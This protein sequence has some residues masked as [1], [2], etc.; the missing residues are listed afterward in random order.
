[1][2]TAPGS[3]VAP[4]EGDL[5]SSDE[6]RPHSTGTAPEDE[7]DLEVYDEGVEF[8]TEEEIATLRRVA[9]KM[10]IGAFAIVIVEL[11]ERFAYYG[12]SGPFQNYLQNPLPPGSTSGAPL[13]GDNGTAGALN[14]GQTAATGLQNMFSFLAYIT[15]IVCG[16]IADVK[17]GRYKTICVFCVVYFVGLLIIT[18]T[19]IPSALSRGAGLAGWIVG[20]IVVAFGTGGIKSNVSPLVADQVRR[21]RMFIKV[22]PSGERVIVDPNVTITRIYNLFYWCINVGSLSAIATTELEHRVGF[23]AAFI[24]P[25]LVFLGTPIVLVGARKTYHKVP[26]RG[27]VVIE[28]FRVT[29]IALRGFWTNPIKYLRESNVTGVWN[30]AKPSYILAQDD[31]FVEEVKRTAKACQ[32]FLFFPLYWISYNQITSNLVSM[33]ADMSLH[34]VPNDLF[35]NFDPIAL[36]ILI[37]I[38][39]IFVYPGLRRIGIIARPV[40][41]IWLGFMFGAVAMV[42]SAVLQHYIYKT[43]PCGDFASGCADADGNPTPSTINVWVQIPAYIL[44]AI[45]EVF[46]SITGLEYAYNKAPKRMKSL[47]MA[48]FLFMVAI[49]NALNAALA[50]VAIDPK[51]VGNYAGIGIATFIAGMVFYLLFYK[52]DRIEEA[53]NEIGKGK[54]YDSAETLTQEDAEKVVAVQA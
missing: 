20:A 54:R 7:V 17:W 49:G 10:P 18:L 50:S 38:M 42:Y 33:A 4:V 52:R 25:T 41:R 28:S 30:R 24:L 53:E 12:L 9:D 1:M 45:S 29:G 37:P 32:I 27:S 47:V 3:K 23:W 44:I 13:D 43:N 31:D 40:A 39:D 22:L 19:S 26:P 46:A 5:G 48:C 8:P 35:Q 21:T 6:K 11:C 36:I 34:G 2:S 51:L 14:M 15:P 16:I